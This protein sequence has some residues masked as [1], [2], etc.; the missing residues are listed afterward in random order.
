MSDL[1]LL[2]Y[3]QWS[4]GDMDIAFDM[5]N[6][7]GFLFEA[8]VRGPVQDALVGPNVTIGK[9]VKIGEGARIKDSILL[10]DISVGA[11]SVIINSIIGWGTNIGT[12]TRIEGILKFGDKKEN[13]TLQEEEFEGYYHNTTNNDSQ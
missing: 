12:W 1:Q 6:A 11:H 9:Y 3:A 8:F 4:A 7:N 13:K 2:L 5:A 10:D